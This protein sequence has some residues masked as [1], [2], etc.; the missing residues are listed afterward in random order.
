MAL[1]ARVFC[2]CFK[3]GRSQPHPFPRLVSIDEYGTALLSED[4]T[5]EQFDQHEAW[6][7]SACPHEGVL[8]A[9][10][11]GNINRV[12]SLREEI[13]RLGASK[14]PIL[15]EEVLYDG[16]HTGDYIPTNEIAALQKEIDAL[17]TSGG[18][19]QLVSFA[20]DMK[21]LA[22]ASQETGNPIVF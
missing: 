12:R 13:Q 19:E 15:L 18:S 11:I 17:L 22:A 5:D 21:T 6:L 10:F 20:R 16:T 3:K 9:K 2:D 8:E 1:D 4:A 7:G 14:F